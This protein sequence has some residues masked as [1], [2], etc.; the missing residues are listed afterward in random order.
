MDA[1][2]LQKGAGYEFCLRKFPE[3][4]LLGVAPANVLFDSLSLSLSTI[5]VF[6]EMD[7]IDCGSSMQVLKKGDSPW[8]KGLKRF[9]L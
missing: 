8:E 5:G 1:E 9:W 3:R 6:R 2:T 4:S 7:F